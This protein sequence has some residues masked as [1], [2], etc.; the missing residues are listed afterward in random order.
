MPY[1]INIEGMHEL[2]FKLQNLCH[3]SKSFCIKYQIHKY[4]DEETDDYDWTYYF[5]GLKSFVC[6]YL[7]QCSIKLRVLLDILKNDDHNKKINYDSIDKKSL[8]NINIGK[9][10]K[11]NDRINVREICNKIIHATDTQFDWQEIEKNKIE[12]WTGIIHLYGK[13]NIEDWELKLNVESFC[14][15]LLRFLN[16]LEDEADWHHLYKYDQ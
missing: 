4:N 8:D 10:L 2:I 3:A 15:V 6:D 13:K 7:I 11:G 16:S 12:F 5:G 14:T 1:D 9:F